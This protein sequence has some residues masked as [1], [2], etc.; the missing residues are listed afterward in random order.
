[1]KTLASMIVMLSALTGADLPFEAPAPSTGGSPSP[2][3]HH[4]KVRLVSRENAAVAGQPVDVA[5]VLES[6]PGWHTY[7]RNPGDAGMATSVT[8]TLPKGW[9]AGE[10]QWPAPR[11]FK[12][13]EIATFGYG[14][15]AVLLSRLEGEWERPGGTLAFRATVDFLEC[16]EVC[17]PGTETVTLELAVKHLGAAATNAALFVEARSRLPADATGWLAT[18]RWSKDATLVVDVTTPPSVK[19]GAAEVRFFPHDAGVIEPSAEARLTERGKNGYS[20]ELTPA[21][22]PASPAPPMLEGV[23]VSR[24]GAWRIQVPLPPRES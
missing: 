20:V 13:K 18:A 16:R 5:I 2:P 17:L 11:L 3:A 7:W 23:L 22:M 1:M 15:T 4:T 6:E 19:I 8:W 21:R 12:E 9:K 10:L 24:S 14:G